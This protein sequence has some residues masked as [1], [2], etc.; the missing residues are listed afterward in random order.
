MLIVSLF[1]YVNKFLWYIQSAKS[2]EYLFVYKYHDPVCM[3]SA[4][5]LHSLIATC[6]KLKNQTAAYILS[7]LKISCQAYFCQAIR[8][9]QIFY[10]D[11]TS[12]ETCPIS[13]N[14][15]KSTF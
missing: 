12:R 10:K 13:C 1:E 14:F 9:R 6:L 4:S 11:L 5:A 3:L 2:W 8:Y 15:F 7:H